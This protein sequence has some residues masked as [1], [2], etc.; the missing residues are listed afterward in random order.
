MQLLILKGINFTIAIYLV[1]SRF[2]F[3]GSYIYI[4]TSSPRRQ[5][6]KAILT[7][8]GANSKSVCLSFY[9]YMYGR[10]INR[11]IIYNAG[12]I[13]WSKSLEQGIGWKKAEVLI[14]GNFDVSV[15]GI[16]HNEMTCLL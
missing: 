15:E 13:I 4:E 6:D 9:Y 12:R 8:K 16:T 10:D 14:N 1:T 7:F 3:A 5:N 11:L 2:L